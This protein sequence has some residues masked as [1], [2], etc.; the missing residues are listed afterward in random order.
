[1]GNNIRPGTSLPGIG[2]NTRPGGVTRPGTGAGGVT[3]PGAG[4]IRPGAGGNRPGIGG[5]GNRPSPGDLGDFLG[6]D[7]PIRPG[8][9]GGG[10]QRPGAGGD[11]RPGA[12]G[13]GIQRPGGGIRPGGDTRPG[14]DGGG[15]QR[16][17]G[18]IRP[19][20]D[21]RPG[22]DG[23]GI[24]RPGIRPGD[25]T[26]PGAGG[27]GERWPGGNRPDWANNRPIINKPINIG[28][29]INTNI[30]RRPTWA[31][32]NNTNITNINRNWNN[33]V[34]R[35]GSPLNNW[36]GTHP[37]RVGYW[38]G[39]AN[40]VRTGW[41][42]HGYHNNWFGSSW[43]GAHRFPACGWNYYRALPYYPYNY[44]WRRPAWTGFATWFTWGAAN[45]AFAQPI[46]YDYGTG[47]NVVY[48]DN[49][50]YIGGQ[51]VATAP[52]FAESAAALATVEPP[53]NEEVAAKAEWQPLG[54]FALSTSEKD[55]EPSRVLQ[56]AVNKD[57]IISGTLFNYE[58]DDA[59]GIQGKVD[60]ETQ[61]VAFRMGD[62]D[63]IVAETGLYNLTQDEAP[64]L[65]HYGKERQE[66]CL[67]VRLENNEK[68][69]E[70]KK[71]ANP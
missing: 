70:E 10:I 18:D 33:V 38:N 25:N 59:Q 23:G 36:N 26:R 3:R 4:D 67:L 44:W 8:A 24:Q 57:G 46:Y 54:T 69:G 13:G 15:I 55:K 40:G 48:Q 27:S 41:N 29:Q 1:M 32:I 52:E 11:T 43:W 66:N 21:T 5:G 71:P 61:R 51:Q 19:G 35:P 30:N 65:I 39:W 22:A 58:T 50:V 56:L 14:A 42:M 28:N 2:N 6:M 7:K 31:N 45:A 47:G 17:G 68:D 64:L 49:S 20:G 60:K 53:A 37:G 63:N 16:P 34:T 12:D 9:G 62:K